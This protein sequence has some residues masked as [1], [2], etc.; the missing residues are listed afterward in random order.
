MEIDTF[1]AVLFAAVFAVPG[2]LASAAFSAAVPRA[3][4]TTESRRLEF[5]SLSCLNNAIWLWLLVLIFQGGLLRS[6]PVWAGLL[7]ML[8]VLVSPL[9]IGVLLG[10]LCTKPRTRTLLAQVGF[11]TQRLIPTAWDYHFSR[12]RA[13]FVIVKLR[14]GSFVYGYYGC[15][16]FAGDDPDCHDIFLERQ[17]RRDKGKWTPI[18]RS[19]GILIAYD[20]IAAIEFRSTDG[21]PHVREGRSDAQTQE[22]GLPAEAEETRHGRVPEHGQGGLP[23]DD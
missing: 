13:C 23:T 6:S 20:Q 14:D 10:R 12:E 22:H 11:R 4:A 7:L 16:S 1:N 19:D 18:D 21:G 8:P 17:Y 15:D 5:L 3:K 2:F 9:L